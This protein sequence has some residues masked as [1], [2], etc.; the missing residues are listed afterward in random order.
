LGCLYDGLEAGVVEIVYPAN[1]SSNAVH[2]LPLLSLSHSTE[3]V[4]ANLEGDVVRY[5]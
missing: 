3:N 1:A 2:A 5:L 4:F